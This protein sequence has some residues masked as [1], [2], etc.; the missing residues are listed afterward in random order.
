MRQCRQALANTIQNSRSR[1][2][3]RGRFV[4]RLNARSCWRSAMFS[5]TNSRWPRQA[6]ASARTLNKI[7][8]STLQS[9]RALPANINQYRGGWLFG[10]RQ[11]FRSAFIPLSRRIR[12]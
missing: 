1:V 4:V 8:S 11:A 7:V 10:E 9:C 6:N 2:R 12:S 5:S 3:R